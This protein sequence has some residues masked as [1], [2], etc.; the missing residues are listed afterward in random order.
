[1]NF[2]VLSYG[3]EMLSRRISDSITIESTESIAIC[4]RILA[5][6]VLMQSVAFIAVVAIFDRKKFLQR[7]LH[8]FINVI[9]SSFLFWGMLY[10]NEKIVGIIK[11]NEQTLLVK[12]F[13]LAVLFFVFFLLCRYLFSR[14][15]EILYL[16]AQVREKDLLFS[17]WAPPLKFLKDSKYTDSTIKLNEQPAIKNYVPV[18]DPLYLIEMYSGTKKCGWI[19][20]NKSSLYNWFDYVSL[21]FLPEDCLDDTETHLNT[22]YIQSIRKVGVKERPTKVELFERSHKIVGP[23]R[24]TRLV[25]EEISSIEILNNYSVSNVCQFRVY[26]VDEPKMVLLDLDLVDSSK[27]GEYPVTVQYSTDDDLFTLKRAITIEINE[28]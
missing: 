27:A 21:S 20:T 14:L 26:K 2:D 11:F 22:K 16:N 24:L 17:I 7:T 5:L 10:L 25:N 6:F 19:L 23:K 15:V 13:Y 4:I 3:F 8:S 12:W 9:S 18:G 28:M 1:M